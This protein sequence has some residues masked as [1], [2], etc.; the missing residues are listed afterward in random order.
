MVQDTQLTLICSKST[1]ETLEKGAKYVQV[2]NKNT[3]TTS[4]SSM[5][6]NAMFEKC[7]LNIFNS[8]FLFDT[9]F[10]VSINVLLMFYQLGMV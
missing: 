8:S 6:F 3:R 4:M 9:T 5:K 2:N 1:I 10:S 7:S